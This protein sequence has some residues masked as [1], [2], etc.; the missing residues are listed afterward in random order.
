MQFL[1]LAASQLR[2]VRPF[3][4]G[5]LGYPE[6]RNVARK[7]ETTKLLK[8]NIIPPFFKKTLNSSVFMTKFNMMYVLLHFEVFKERGMI[9][10]HE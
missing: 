4:R 5:F 2:Y 7:S 9:S 1:N 6:G 8:S 3:G 10:R